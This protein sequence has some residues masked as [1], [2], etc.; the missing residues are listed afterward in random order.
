M[1]NRD[2]CLSVGQPAVTLA[3]HVHS[4]RP[5]H[6]LLHCTRIAAGFWRNRSSA[7]MSTYRTV[8]ARPAL[9]RHLPT[10]F[11]TTSSRSTRT[12]RHSVAQKQQQPQTQL[13]NTFQVPKQQLLD[14]ASE[15]AARLACVGAA[16]VLCMCWS[17]EAAFA[18]GRKAPPI[19]ESAGRCDVAALDKFAD[20]SSSHVKKKG[21]V[22]SVYK[23]VAHLASSNALG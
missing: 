19:S 8:T 3:K 17:P 21:G 10:P 14:Q 23:H 1:Y 7:S 2:L 18:A 12:A 15:L 5:T 6:R 11:S 4:D 16:A 20:V 13:V 9:T 22:C